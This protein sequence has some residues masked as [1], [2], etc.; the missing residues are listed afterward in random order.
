MVVLESF[1]DCSKL[2]GS[3]N[4]FNCAPIQMKRKSVLEQ[5]LVICLKRPL[6]IIFWG[7]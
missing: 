3:F 2:K 7:K 5:N 6:R 4:A 1:N